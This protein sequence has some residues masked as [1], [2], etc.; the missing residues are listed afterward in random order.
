[1]TQAAVSQAAM[2][3]SQGAHSALLEHAFSVDLHFRSPQALHTSP[4]DG[5]CGMPAAPPS[6]T[7]S[8]PA[9]PLIVMA[10]PPAVLAVPEVGEPPPPLLPPSVAPASPPLPEVSAAE[11]PSSPQATTPTPTPAKHTIAQRKPVACELQVDL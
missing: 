8:A 3:L 10:T 6:P 1:V 9:A 2:Q 11:S 7:I 5:A 4:I